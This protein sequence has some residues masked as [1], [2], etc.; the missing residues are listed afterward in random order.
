MLDVMWLIFFIQSKEYKASTLLQCI[1]NFQP[2]EM[3]TEVL[4]LD[5][6]LNVEWKS[7]DQYL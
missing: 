7:L 6:N 4:I 2:G 3:F 1:A 5:G